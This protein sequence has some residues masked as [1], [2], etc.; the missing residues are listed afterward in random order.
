LN[1]QPGPSVSRRKKA[2]HIPDE[3]PIGLYQDDDPV[4]L[5][6]EDDDIVEVSET[7]KN[8]R[9]PPLRSSTRKQVSITVDEDV[10]EISDDDQNDDCGTLIAKLKNVRNVVGYS[11]GLIEYVINMQRYQLCKDR[12]LEHAEDVLSDSALAIVELLC[13]EGSRCPVSERDTMLTECSRSL[14]VQGSIEDP[15][16][17]QASRV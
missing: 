11:L 12:G 4:Q 15:C 16:G 2:P 13:P 10:V 14:H 7:P 8:F 3:E 17:G 9:W 6:D 5:P 1:A